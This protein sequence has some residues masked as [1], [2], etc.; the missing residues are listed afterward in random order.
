MTPLEMLVELFRGT[1]TAVGAEAGACLRAPDRQPAEWWRT[2]V[3]RHFT[4]EGPPIGV[5]PIVSLES[6]TMSGASL[7]CRWGCIDYDDNQT[8]LVYAYNTQQ[9]L[10]RFGIWSWI[11]TSR[12]KGHHLWVFHQQWVP[13]RLM[14]TALLAAQQL[15]G[16][17]PREVNPKQMDLAAGQLGNYVRLPYPG[18]LGPAADFHLAGGRRVV[19]D[20]LLADFDAV[21]RWVI[22]G[23]GAEEFAQRA[24]A[25]RLD[26]LAPLEEL[27]RRYEP[28]PP[29][30]RI[31]VGTDLSDDDVD[32][33]LDRVLPTLNGL[34]YTIW[35]DGPSA[36]SD[37][38]TTLARLAYKVAENVPA[39]SE[40]DCLCVLVDLDRRLGK[41][42]GRADGQQQL[43]KMV[44][45][46]YAGRPN[47][48][49]PGGA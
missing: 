14:R 45:R 24:Y 12:S 33:A 23:Y 3:E 27:A 26:D 39:V 18:G 34:A 10:E 19:I 43:A 1:T 6:G 37:R 40:V 16:I 20:A 49:T 13:V 29:P 9:L 48:S 5:Y 32:A 4:G 7:V 22:N 11:E 30:K 15:L 31:H 17:P 38:S 42:V 46:A 28:P 47:V 2:E 36:G 25:A 44:G 8:S 21:D 35:R 41:F